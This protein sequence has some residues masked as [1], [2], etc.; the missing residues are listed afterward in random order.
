MVDLEIAKIEFEKYVNQYNL[1]SPKMK[2]K[3]GHSYRVMENAGEIAESLNLDKEEIEVAKLIG[4]L[5]DIAKFGQK[6]NDDHGDMG[7]QFLRESNYIRK[8]IEDDKYDDI[9]LKAI[10]NHNKFQIEEGLTDKELLFAKIIRDADKLDNFRVKKEEK[11]EEIFPGKVTK[12][13]EFNNSLISEKVYDNI[14]NNECVDVRDRVHPLDYWICIL[15]FAFDINF[16]ETFEIIKENDYINVLIDK[17]NYTNTDS[18]NKMEEIRK[19]INEF[20]EKRVN[21]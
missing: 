12:I 2:R 9:I 3:L 19:I 17:F 7:A 15:A 1:E 20:V 6:Y 21:N 4:L 16:K 8:Y 18:A 10:K 11:I 13:E 5:H 14:L